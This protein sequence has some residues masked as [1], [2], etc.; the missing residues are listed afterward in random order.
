MNVSKIG[1]SC[2]LHLFRQTEYATIQPSSGCIITENKI[3]L[4]GRLNSEQTQLVYSYQVNWWLSTETLLFSFG[5]FS[6][7]PR[8]FQR[9][10]RFFLPYKLTGA[11][12]RV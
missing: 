2:A 6:W 7:R 5:I 3:S 11:F 1:I 8:S 10:D 4:C 12:D 9:R